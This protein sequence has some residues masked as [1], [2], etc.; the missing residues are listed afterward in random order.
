MRPMT[1]NVIRAIFA[2][3]IAT[4]YHS[5]QPVLVAEGQVVDVDSRVND[6]DPNAAAIKDR[7][8]CYLTAERSRLDAHGLCSGSI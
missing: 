4:D 3:K 6:C 7:R 2:G 1:V 5:T 8:G